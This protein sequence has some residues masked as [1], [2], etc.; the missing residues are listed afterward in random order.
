MGAMDT[1]QADLGFVGTTSSHASHGQ[2]PSIS[3][4]G[5]PCECGVHWDP[6]VFPVLGRKAWA[7]VPMRIWEMPEAGVQGG[8]VLLSGLCHQPPGRCRPGGSGLTLG[9]WRP[10]CGAPDQGH[11]EMA[12]AICKLSL[13]PSLCWAPTWAGAPMGLLRPVGSL[14]GQG[15][16]WQARPWGP[17]GPWDPAW[18]GWPVGR[19]SHGG[20]SGLR[21]QC[22]FVPQSGT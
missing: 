12:G 17:S 14:T 6:Q 9:T 15:G 18:A 1:A 11:R 22:S 7:E 5:L 20:P 2:V 3:Q 13:C 19:H 4:A 10:R 8:Q 16:Q 21:V